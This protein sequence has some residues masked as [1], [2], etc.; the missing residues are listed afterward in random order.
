MI[1][2]TATRLAGVPGVQP[3]M[4]VCNRLH[5]ASIVSQLDEV[6]A[7]PS[8]VV[9]EPTGRHTAAAVTAAALA[10]PEDAVLA[11]LPADHVIADREALQVALGTA[12]DAAGEGWLVTFG[13]VPE[14]AE[15]GYGY[16]EA[17]D[18]TEVRRILEFVEK[19]DA[20]TAAAFLD[21]RHFWNSGMF[22]FRVD[23][24]LDELR[25]HAPEIVESVSAAMRPPV[26]GVVT[27]GPTFSD[28]PAVPFDVAVMERTD[29]AVMV[30]LDAGWDDIG[31]WRSLWE[32]AR[33]DADENARV[34]DVVAVDAHRSYLRADGRP[35]VV[36]GL[37]DVV[38]VD[39]GDVVFV[40]SMQR[41]QDV[42]DL[43]GFLDEHRPD[44]T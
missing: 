9:A 21:G 44:L 34:G 25:R 7:R 42:R 13:I 37:D 16:I 15:T 8:T 41:A 12:V 39:A 11:V 35:V 38:V 23:V 10:A 29:R 32:T 3:P 31:S 43:V 19:P 1:Q 30:P 14:R 27:L 6:G 24:V 36:L 17:A 20:D 2:Q 33:R 18:G 22:V 28:T 40:A 5:V 26:D 4:V